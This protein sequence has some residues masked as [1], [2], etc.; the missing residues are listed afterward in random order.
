MKRTNQIGRAYFSSIRGYHG[1]C[2]PCHPEEPACSMEVEEIFQDA[3]DWYAEVE[4]H[5]KDLEEKRKEIVLIKNMARQE[6]DHGKKR[7]LNVERD[8][9]EANRYIKRLK[10]S[11][12]SHKVLTAEMM[13]S[14]RRHHNDKCSQQCLHRF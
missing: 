11:L 4:R 13:A 2:T 3:R 7:L 6:K 1:D 5:E 9:F 14:S 12:A 8:L 10:C